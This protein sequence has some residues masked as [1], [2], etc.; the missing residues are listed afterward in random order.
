ME[1]SNKETAIP[2]PTQAAGVAATPARAKVAT[3]FIVKATDMELLAISGRILA[4]LTG[5][6]G[7]ASPVPTLAML[8]AARNA[9]ANAVNA[10]DR[11]AT[12]TAARNKT[13]GALAQVLRDLAL[14]VQHTCQGD[15]VMLNSSGFPAQRRRGAV[16]LEAPQP[17][18]QIKLTRG[19]VSGQVKVRCKS[20]AGAVLYQCR[21]A[22]AAAPT[23]WTL[24]DTSTSGGLL[25]DGLVP[26]T[27]Y[28]VQ[29]RAYGKRG[30]SDWSDS[31]TVV[32]S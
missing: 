29:A 1:T 32:A 16:V 5:N 9:Y 21:Y 15:L 23:A 2:S 13:R 14:Y 11:G 28:L 30:C 17:P 25:L 26:V 27:A 7:Y 12:S 10:L 3:S 20:V 18:A 6:A 19:P 24:S 31:A 8:L 22:T 4:G